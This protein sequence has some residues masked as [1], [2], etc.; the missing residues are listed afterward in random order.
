MNRDR[1]F[2][3]WKSKFGGSSSKVHSTPI[4]PVKMKPSQYKTDLNS[5]GKIIADKLKRIR[6]VIPGFTDRKGYTNMA[7]V[8]KKWLKNFDVA[9]KKRNQM[10]AGLLV[11]KNKGHFLFKKPFYKKPALNFNKGWKKV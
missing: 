9:K 5:Y 4:A 11:G 7:K 6:D 3:L 2:A 8:D 1:Q 10:A